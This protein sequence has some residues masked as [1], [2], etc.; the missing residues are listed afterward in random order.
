MG[1]VGVIGFAAGTG[2]LAM[3]RCLVLWVPLTVG[4][5]VGFDFVL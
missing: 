5:E 3:A 4:C 1:V 2:E